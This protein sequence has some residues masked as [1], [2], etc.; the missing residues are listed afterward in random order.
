MLMTY[1]P[2]QS[3]QLIAKGALAD[4]LLI[5]TKLTPFEKS[6]ADRLRDWKGDFLP[7]D[8]RILNEIWERY[9]GKN[10][11]PMRSLIRKLTN[12]SQKT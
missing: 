10:K 4:L 6:F 5:S 12:F 1:T 9:Y 7:G 11:K 2:Q 3:K 8:L